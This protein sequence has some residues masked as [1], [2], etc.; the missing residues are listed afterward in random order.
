MGHCG[1]GGRI[2]QYNRI[3]NRFAGRKEES[4][5][6][7]QKLIAGVDEHVCP[8]EQSRLIADALCF[9]ALQ[10]L[11]SL[12]QWF[13]QRFIMK[14]GPRLRA[15]FNEAPEAGIYSAGTQVEVFC[16]KECVVALGESLHR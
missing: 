11:T 15:G 8:P 4:F 7:A 2:E 10:M 16:W 5:T 14:A 1:D 9:R 6:F 12:T 3:R 13:S